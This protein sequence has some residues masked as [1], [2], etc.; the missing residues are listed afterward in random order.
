M[1]T[2][3]LPNIESFHTLSLGEQLGAIDLL[4][5]P[6]PALHALV[7]GTLSIKP[8]TSYTHLIQ[9]IRSCVATLLS[10]PSSQANLH[11][12]LGSHPRLGA[13]K[14]DS[15]QSAA[16]QARLQQGR[17]EER[18][19]L[20]KLNEEYEARFPGLRYVV[21]VDGRGR[22]EIMDDMRARIEV[23]DLK[24]E[25]CTAIQVSRLYCDVNTVGVQSIVFL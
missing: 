12:I 3:R 25:E 16:E 15:A 18:A 14:V 23:G 8:F 11:A 20:A 10:S 19:Q 7:L 2:S 21:F 1:A 24:A 22:P 4:F 5:E 17:E 6:S 13:G 9:H